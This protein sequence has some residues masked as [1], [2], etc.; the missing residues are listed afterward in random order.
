MG[1]KP[2]YNDLVKYNYLQKELTRLAKCLG[3]N[4]PNVVALNK[5][6][7][8]LALKLQIRPTREGK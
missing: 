7:E 2:D 5:E 6:V 3:V 8:Q 4:H 1:E